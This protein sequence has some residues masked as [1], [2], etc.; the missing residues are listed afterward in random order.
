MRS[1]SSG[2]SSGA[3]LRRPRV[4][5]IDDEE[6]ICRAIKRA[7]GAGFDVATSTNPKDALEE[8]EAGAIYDVILCDFIMPRMTGIELYER[9]RQRLPSAAASMIFVTGDVNRPEYQRF[10]AATGC[11]CLPKPYAAAALLAAIRARLE[12][13]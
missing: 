2:L 11:V 8:L 5:V 3:Q 1:S 6:M 4:L 10:L 13:R 7:L 9:L 12:S